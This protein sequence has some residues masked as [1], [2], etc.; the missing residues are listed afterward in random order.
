[1]QS[2]FKNRVV[3]LL[4]GT[5][6]LEQLAIW[7]RNIALLF[8]VMESTGNSPAAVSLLTVVEI[9]PILLFSLIGGAL[10]DRWEPRRTMRA[11]QLLSALSV[12]IILIL[13]EN[14]VWQAVFAA[15]AVS[16]IVSQFSQPSTAV[17]I[18][19]HLPPEQIAAATGLS[20]SL[21]SLFLI[22][23]PVIGTGIYT[24]LGLDACLIVIIV[25]FLISFMVMSFLP[26]LTRTQDEGPKSSLLLEMK[27]GIRVVLDS[28]TLSALAAAFAILGLGMGLVQPLDIF[29][30]TDRLGLQK[31]Q[32]QWFYIASGVG[33]LGGGILSAYLMQ[34]RAGK[35]PLYY[36][37][38][39]L[40]LSLVVEVLSVWPLLTGALRLGV[41]FS[42]AFVQAAISILILRLVQERYIGR[43]SGAIT[44]LFTGTLLI[45]TA[46][47]GLLLEATSLF[48]VY[49]SAAAVTLMAAL[50]CLR[51]PSTALEAPL[52]NEVQ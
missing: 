33:M 30:I 8:Y 2:L 12:G 24:W 48:A 31:E 27:E 6:L 7:I 17:M 16:A 26:T 29:I 51:L 21:I 22:A 45:G 39:F 49:F 32:V 15:T 50:F 43:V 3:L 23:G 25:L 36:G 19:R 14:G 10:A 5:D 47:S 13:I 18:K 34:N 4:L 46:V 28:R 35:K 40:S 38:C 44:P 11:G 52:V 41:G 9:A 20:Q 42:M 37:L 1:M